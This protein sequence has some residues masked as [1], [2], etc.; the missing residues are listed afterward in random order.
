MY[1]P[2]KRPQASDSRRKKTS[3]GATAAPKHG[4]QPQFDQRDKASGPI[5]GRSPGSLRGAFFHN[6][7][8]KIELFDGQTGFTHMCSPSSQHSGHEDPLVIAIDGACPGNGTIRA[9]KS[10][11][12]VFFA[13]G[14]PKNMAARIP[15]HLLEGA[16]HTNNIAEITSAISALH[17]ATIVARG[18]IQRYTDAVKHG[19]VRKPSG[20]PQK[21]RHVVVKSD[22][23]YV[24]KS[25]A[26]GKKGEP[27]YIA[28]WE[29]NGFRTAGG[30][31]YIDKL[32]EMG[33]TVQFWHVR[34]ELNK[35]AD[36]LAN[37]GL[38]LGA[39]AV[40]STVE[41]EIKRVWKAQGVSR[42]GRNHS[43]ENEV[44]VLDD[45]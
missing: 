43:N 27:P 37:E 16:K 36:R 17:G 18:G 35:D 9:T 3:R 13:P 44:I 26:G 33:V 10:G 31:A 34:R 12:G 20:E 29:T 8:G 45:D 22:S 42:K 30:G 32:R 11:Y 28:K 2:Y 4:D 24:V 41:E 38:V 5:L 6:N 40:S 7:D 21:L 1:H 23:E 39:S 14:N 25:I 15:N 19:D